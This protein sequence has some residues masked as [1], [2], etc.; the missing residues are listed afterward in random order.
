MEKN[1]INQI[2][3]LVEE[4]FKEMLDKDTNYFFN[5]DS[6]VDDAEDW[7]VKRYPSATLEEGCEFR[8]AARKHFNEVYK[9]HFNAT[10]A[11][12]HLA[13]T[14]SA[15]GILMAGYNRDMHLLKGSAS[16]KEKVAENY[17]NLLD[18]LYTLCYAQTEDM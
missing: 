8:Q 14:T 2:N 18:S 16:Q 9:R 1:Q 13:D 11:Y 12:Y 3:Q 7:Y 15:I 4:F 10:D 17:K 5:T 6:W